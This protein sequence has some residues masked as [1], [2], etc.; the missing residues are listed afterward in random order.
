MFQTYDSQSDPAR[1]VPRLQALRSAL[2]ARKLDGF[3]V[4]RADAHQGEYVSARDARLAWLTGFTGSAGFCIVTAERAG[5]FI[6]GRYRVQV[7]AEVD[8]THFTPVAWPEVK[9]AEW[10]REALAEGGRIGFDPW[11]HTRREIRE[12]EKALAGSGIGLHPVQGNPVDAIWADQPDA[13][14]G[15]VRLWSDALAGE[16][17]AEKRAR[18]A[19]MLRDADQQAAVLTLPDSISWLLNIRGADVP[20]NPVVQA[21]AIIEED[22]RVA[23]FTNPAKFGPEVRAALGNEVSILPFDALT[24]ALT[25]LG[26]P[27]RVDPATA[28]EQV[29]RLIESMSTPISE[30]VDPVIMPKAV[31]N[32]AEIGGMRAAHLRDGAAIVE[33]LCWL[34]ARAAELDAQP[35]TEIA[36]ARKLEALRAAQGILDISFDTILGSGPNG[37]IVH[38]RVTDATDRR[39]RPGDVLL[40][41]SGGQYGDGTT[42]ITR[43]LPMGPVD[44]KVRHPYTRVLQ[45][46]IAMSRA[47][48]P[49]GV[50]G[51]HIDA[52]A[53]APLWSDGMD[54]DHGTG[55]GVGAGLSVHEGPVRLSRVSDIPLRA[56]MILSNEPGY[57]RE[58]EFGIR[59]ENLIVVRE[60]G[61]PDGRDMLGFETLTL[62]PIDQRLIEPGLMSASE[63]DWLDA[64]HARVRDEIGPLVSSEAREWLVAATQP[65]TV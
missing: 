46:M 3:L 19:A 42:D 50:A 54:Y 48:F 47:R 6:D 5:V 51:C 23:V 65:L 34:D 40:V 13:P 17:A 15:A 59:I 24:V 21:F 58:G 55:H 37:A 61:N 36:V 4:P 56:G 43:T 38:Y 60:A 26:G 12:L 35:L 57:Y 63:R 30:E 25:N 41:D 2:T 39:I 28:P 62:A 29:F 53:R 33:L 9:A 32:E 14:I 10:L 22:G 8:L 7:K 44:A 20:K 18:I 64:Y 31:K 27:V 49:H 45:G 52:L 16:T 11:L 1:H